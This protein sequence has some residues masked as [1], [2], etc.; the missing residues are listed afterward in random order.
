[1]SQADQKDAEAA[2]KPAKAEKPSKSAPQQYTDTQIAEFRAA[3]EA[4][5][6]RKATD[7]DPVKWYRHPE[8]NLPVSKRTGLVPLEFLKSIPE[9]SANKGDVKGILPKTAAILL[10]KQ[11]VVRVRP[12]ALEAISGQ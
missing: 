1:M 7:G 2:A 10:A 9:L 6:N 11:G 3:Y 4:E 8:T 5:Q 12:A